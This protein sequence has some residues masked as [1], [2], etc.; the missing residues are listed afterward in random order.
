M[1]HST[2]N[3]SNQILVPASVM[4]ALGLRMG[5]QVWWSLTKDGRA[6]IQRGITLN[7][8]LTPIPW[9]EKVK[10]RD[11][12]SEGGELGAQ[13]AAAS[14]LHGEDRIDLLL[15]TEGLLRE[16]SSNATAGVPIEIRRKAQ[17]LLQRF[18]SIAELE[19]AFPTSPQVD[20]A[21]DRSSQV[22]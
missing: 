5:M 2:I 9:P 7:P 20:S 8:D 1:A 18:P 4:E 6:T 16:L 17:R 12:E 15:Q 3:S 13:Q 10:K 19:A 21:S 11:T 22:G 14:V